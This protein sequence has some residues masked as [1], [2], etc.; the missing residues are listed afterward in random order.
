MHMTQ[1]FDTVCFVWDQGNSTL[2]LHQK[3]LEEADR[4]AL[5]FGYEPKCW[6]KPKTWWNV[7]KTFVNTPGL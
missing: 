5:E 2:I 3:T 1:V 4:I 7:K 6:Y